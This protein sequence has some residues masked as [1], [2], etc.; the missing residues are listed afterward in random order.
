MTAGP[1]EAFVVQS[2][3]A[4]FASVCKVYAPLY[5]QVTLTALRAAA[6]GNTGQ[7]AAFKPAEKTET[8]EARDAERRARLARHPYLAKATK[9]REGLR[10]RAQEIRA[11]RRPG[12]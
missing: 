2:Q 4:R 12:R 9:L 6:R 1:E 3:L 8:E 11:R 5:R 10:Q 7:N